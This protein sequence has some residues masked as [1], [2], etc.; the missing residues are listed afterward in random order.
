MLMADMRIVPIGSSDRILGFFWFLKM[1]H[2]N[3]PFGGSFNGD[4]NLLDR[5]SVQ[6][7]HAN[8]EID[9]EYPKGNTH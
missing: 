8:N 7:A 6:S 3:Q 2:E 9:I 4:F 5:T 1:M